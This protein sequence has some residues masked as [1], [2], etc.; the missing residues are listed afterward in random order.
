[1]P[2]LNRAENSQVMIGSAI[3]DLP[4]HRKVAVDALWRFDLTPL[5]VETA[6]AAH[7]NAAAYALGLVEQAV[8]YVG[9][10]A[11]RY[12][13]VPRNNN[14]EQISIMEMEYRRA[15]ER[16]I[17]ILIFL[18]SNEHQ[19]PAKMTDLEQFIETNPRNKQ[20]LVAFRQSLIANHDVF[21]FKSPEDLSAQMIR[22]LQPLCAP[23]EPR[24]SGLHAPT[25]QTIP[26]LPAPY[27]AHPHYLSRQLIGRRAELETLDNWAASPDPLMIVHGAGGMGKSALVWHWFLRRAMGGGG[28][29]GNVTQNGQ[30]A[31]MMQWTFHESDGSLEKFVRHALAYITEKPLSAIDTIPPAARM[32]RLLD[33]LREQH[34][35]LLLESAERLL[36]AYN[37]MDAPYLADSYADQVM[38][39]GEWLREC[40]DSRA[41][42]F[43]AEL[44]TA[45]PSK[46]LLNSRLIPH[47]TQLP[48]GSLRPGAQQLALTG[49]AIAD[50]LALFDHLGLKGKP[51]DMTELIE[52]L[53]GHPLML[54]ALAGQIRD[55]DTWYQDE[56][57]GRLVLR[58][59]DLDAKDRVMHILDYITSGL[60]AAERRLLNTIAAFRHP[61]GYA[62]L[63]ALNPYLDARPARVAE[64]RRWQGNYAQA[65]AVYDA[66]LQA[67]EKYEEGQRAEHPRLHTAL[68]HLEAGGLLQWDRATNRYDVRP[69]VRASMFAGWSADERATT[70]ARLR[71]YY[72]S[73]PAGDVPGEPSD[74]RRNVEIYN[75]LLAGGLIDEAVDFY[76]ANLSKPLAAL[77]DQQ[78]TVLLMTPLFPE[79]PTTLPRLRAPRDRV[80]VAN[81]MAVAL[82]KLS[83]ND[84]ALALYGLAL[85]PL[86][87]E[88]D[89]ARLCAGLMN[90]AGLLHDSSRMAAKLRAFEMARDLASAIG[91]DESLAAAQLFLLRAYVDIG[92]WNAAE[93]A[94]LGFNACNKSPQRQTTAERTYA[95]MLI[96]R[97]QD[98]AAALNL[99][100]TLA[101]ETQSSQEKRAIHQL[102]G[103]AGLQMNRPDAAIRFF[104][105]AL[106][107]SAPGSPTAVAARSG[108]ARAYVRLNRLDE[109]RAMLDKGI[110][111]LAIAEIYQ[112]S[113]ELNHA[114][115][116]ALRAYRA[117]W[118]EG[119]PFV[120]VYDL[121]QARRLL[122]ELAVEEPT[123]PE[124]DPSKDPGI[125]GEQDIRAFIDQLNVKGQS[126]AATSKE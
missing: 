43:L 40:A 92:W 16:G 6:L 12:G 71:E 44:V 110:S 75:A 35:I 103:E 73:L 100:W 70:F 119:L 113:R 3:R 102:W 116:A 2:P 69:L 91:D 120:Q 61:V 4:E 18:M 83:R 87:D 67:M 126:A 111:N 121:E 50:A 49:L 24:L 17:P 77:N 63:Y 20:K 53:D 84:E 56:R 42:K 15:V 115:R 94:H 112:A 47:E 8:A 106:D 114:V 97:G 72:E 32:K 60:P 28:G 19:P 1:M 33:A 34:Y 7:D 90:Y 80:F 95:R 9:L 5:V 55:F 68:L 107:L 23:P 29:A 78:T 38:H 22:A 57:H 10:V 66:Y 88:G 81:E 54:C 74:L 52:S 58:L 93:T 27:I 13:H 31:G 26:P 76:R 105:A 86:I 108:I 46:I 122:K 79:G 25:V 96:Y 64:P 51:T 82:G 45:S 14:P 36:T 48:D 101:T 104:Q 109:A 21:Y 124:Y 30:I 37:R 99:A 11:L 117:A 123:L 41:G 39:G 125:P 118:G 62:A 65:R 59:A 85:R 98:P 89:A